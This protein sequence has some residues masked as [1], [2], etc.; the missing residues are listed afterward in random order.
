MTVFSSFFPI[1]TIV[2][3]ILLQKP[4]HKTCTSILT[5]TYRHTHTY[6]E[7]TQLICMNNWH[8]N[9]C[10]ALIPLPG[11]YGACSREKQKY[12]TVTVAI[13]GDPGG[14]GGGG[15]DVSP[16]EFFWGDRP[17]PPL[18]FWKLEKYLFK[19]L[20][21]KHNESN[22]KRLIQHKNTTKHTKSFKFCRALRAQ[23]P[24]QII[25]RLPWHCQPLA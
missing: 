13:G 1:R 5:Q 10:V 21:F 11:K 8:F 15:G 24:G 4:T 19:Y 2:A 25:Y 9:I 18:D 22:T 12:E 17:P 20:H 6:N 23:I 16:L 14:T 7:L 3:L